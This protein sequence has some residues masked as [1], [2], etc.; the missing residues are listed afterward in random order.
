MNW[1]RYYTEILILALAV[2][3]VGDAL[4]FDAGRSATLSLET[5]NKVAEWCSV[6]GDTSLFPAETSLPR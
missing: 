3:A 2:T 4:Q 6:S 5:G 1:E